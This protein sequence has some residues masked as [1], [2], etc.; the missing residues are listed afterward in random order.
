[1]R[2]CE[3]WLSRLEDRLQA[4][5]LEF[6]AAMAPHTSL[7]VGGPADVLAIAQR[8]E[9]LALMV[10]EAR[11]LDVP[12]T[13]IGGGSN[14]LVAD[15]GVRGVVVLN[16]CRRWR[17]FVG[18]DRVP[19]VWAESGVLLAGLARA[20]IRQGLDGLTWAVHIPGTVGGAVVGNAGAHGGCI[21]DVLEKVTLMDADGH[22]RDVGPDALAY[23]YRSSRLKAAV[24]S[25]EPT[26]VVMSATFRLTPKPAA[27]LLARAER[28]VAYR[29][30][31]QPAEPS[32][33][34]IFRNPE[35]DFAGRL[36]E[37]AGLKG[38]RVGGAMIS[39]VHAN[40]IVN[41]E[42]GTAADVET[43]MREAREAVLARFGVL[44]VP[45]IVFLGDWP[46]ATW[47]YWRQ[48]ERSTPARSP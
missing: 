8:A 21:A 39:P 42:Q 33:G 1:M 27:A 26:P 4:T 17:V 48:A 44:L 36:M 35:G 37:A 24:A 5:V 23:S 47:R 13:V 15:S 22:V 3:R 10:L 9:D 7:R 41:I 14:V 46:E 28:F 6:G 43:L 45:E 12:V 11:E 19:R 38:R 16:R 25:G 31:T 20:L 30:E 18:R 2:A 29:R 32:V 40:F 34:S